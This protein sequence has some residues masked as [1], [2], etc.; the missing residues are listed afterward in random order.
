[1]GKPQEGTNPDIEGI[2]HAV[3]PSSFKG[4]IGGS[5]NRVLEVSGPSSATPGTPF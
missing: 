1:M 5:S 3:F 2:L 4:L